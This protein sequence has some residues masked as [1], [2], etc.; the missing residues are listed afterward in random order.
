MGRAVCFTQCTD[1]DVHLIQKHL[2]H[3]PRIVV[4]QTSLHPLAQSRVRCYY[5]DINQV[6]FK[7]VSSWAVREGFV[8]KITIEI[9]DRNDYHL[10]FL[11][12][13]INIQG[14]EVVSHHRQI[15]S[16]KARS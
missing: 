5:R 13:E 2:T 12:E 6:P 15:G 11:K 9:V 10:Y 4:D 16:D 14:D 3:R 1:A 7:L 8:K